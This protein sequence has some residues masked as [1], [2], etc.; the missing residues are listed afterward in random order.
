MLLPN[1]Q[2]TTGSG[3]GNVHIEGDVVGHR[4]E[5]SRAGVLDGSIFAVE[6]VVLANDLG[7]VGA[8]RG[9]R[10]PSD[11]LE[12]KGPRATAT[13]A[14]LP[15]VTILADLDEILDYEFP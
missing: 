8:G 12:L 1:G 9:P 3:T 14:V 7:V 4:V 2:I 10:T 15:R 6:P 5:I 13:L 11:S